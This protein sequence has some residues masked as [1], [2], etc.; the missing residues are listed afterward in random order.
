MFPRKLLVYYNDA[1]NKI[2]Y[3]SKAPVYAERI[4]VDPAK[5]MAINI[6]LKKKLDWNRTISGRV[7]HS[8][9]IAKGQL[10]SLIEHEKIQFCID[11]WVK[12]KKWEDT[13]AFKYYKKQGWKLKKIVARHKTLDEIF[14]EVKRERKIKT[15][16]EITSNNFREENGI[17]INIGPEG[18]LVFAD[19]GSH[20]LAIAVI[21]QLPYI[22]A[23]I[24]CVHVEAI[25]LLPALRLKNKDDSTI[26][27]G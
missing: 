4:W 9:P 15:A 19:G 14:E 8:W 2:T 23:Q 24:G 18:E 20:R 1:K 13:G 7:I 17:R 6:C 10:I 27:D 25:S 26:T 11:R 16:K 3:G 21:L 5:C 12:G 22:P